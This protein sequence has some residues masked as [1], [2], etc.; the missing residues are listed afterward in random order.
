MARK[1]LNK[2]VAAIGAVFLLIIFAGVGYVGYQRFFNRNPEKFLQ[3]AREAHSQK[4]YEEVEK[5][6]GMAYGCTKDDS[7][8]IE[9]LFEMAEFH[10]IDDGDFHEPDWQKAMDRWNRVINID[11]KNTEARMKMLN[12]FYEGSDSGNSFLWS[13]VDKNS[14]ELIEVMEEKQMEANPYVLLARGRATLELTRMGQM[15]DREAGINQAKDEFE[16]V[17]AL[18]PEDASIYNY[19]AQVFDF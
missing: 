6:Y 17:L 16:K 8:R 2:K 4:N 19:L 3:K 1:K 12:Y 5:N 10:L 11:P 9:I 15:T 13:M 14:S 7:F 18:T